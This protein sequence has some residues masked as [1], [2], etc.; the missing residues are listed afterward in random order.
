MW[1]RKTTNFS[2]QVSKQGSPEYVRV[3]YTWHKV[4][5]AGVETCQRVSQCSALLRVQHASQLQRRVLT[6]VCL[7]SSHTGMGHTL[8]RTHAI[9]S[10]SK[11]GAILC[12][13]VCLFIAFHPFY[14]TYV[15]AG[16]ECPA[17]TTWLL[18]EFVSC[19]A[20][21]SVL[22]PTEE[23]NGLKLNICLKEFL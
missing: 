17:G 14:V 15:P 13:C 10:L 16:D 2:G 5:K 1:L 20:S 21:C 19:P 7:L 3:V 6:G 12:A 9:K 18:P 11:H 23:N 8:K 4:A 22:F